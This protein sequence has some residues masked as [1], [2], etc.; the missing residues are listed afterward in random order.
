MNKTFFCLGFHADSCMN[1]P[2]Q[3]AQQFNVEVQAG[4]RAFGSPGNTLE[5]HGQGLAHWTMPA[6]QWGSVD[7]GFE[8]GAPALQPCQQGILIIKV[9]T[10]LMCKN[11][12]AAYA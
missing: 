9:S 5:N 3:V 1:R 4:L 10:L 7:P 8:C 11:V 2:R 6:Q 12:H